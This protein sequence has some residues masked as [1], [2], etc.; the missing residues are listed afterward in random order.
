VR[1][2]V[3]YTSIPLPYT[4]Y[5]PTT[6][7]TRVIY[8]RVYQCTPSLPW[9][10]KLTWRFRLRTPT[11]TYVYEYIYVHGKNRLQLHGM[12][13]QVGFNGPHWQTSSRV[14][15]AN[16]RRLQFISRRATMTARY[17]R[18]RFSLEREKN[19][20]IYDLHPLFPYNLKCKQMF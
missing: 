4:V 10:C 17:Q 11:Y 3:R 2:H 18:S 16:L 13:W 15:Y 12:Y 8:V 6:Q 14:W 5:W 20:F 1:V 19:G 9:K 7:C